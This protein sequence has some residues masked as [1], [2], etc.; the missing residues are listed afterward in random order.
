[1]ARLNYL[2]QRNVVDALEEA[3]TLA[4]RRNRMYCSFLDPFEMYSDAQFIKLYRLSKPLTMELIDLLEP[5]L[6]APSRKSALCIPRKILTTLR[7]LASGSYQLDVGRNMNHAVSQSSVSNV[8]HEVIDALNMPDIF[9]KYIHLPRNRDE[10]SDLRNKFYM[11]HNFPGI[12]GSI[13]CTHIAI[14]AP[15]R[16][17]YPEEAYVNRKGYHSLNV[18]LICDPDLEILNVCARY[19]GSSHD[20]YIFNNSAAYQYIRQLYNNGYT[21]F[22]FLGDSGYALRPW[23]LTPIQN[24]LPGSPEENYNI[25]Q[26][27]ARSIIER[28][29]GVLK[30]RF[31]CL[32][33]HRVLHYDPTT[34][35][36]IIN[37]CTVLHNMC[38]IHNIPPVEF[39]D[40]EEDNYIDIDYGIY[41]NDNDIIQVRNQGQELIAGRRLQQLLIRNH[42][43]NF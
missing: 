12:I 26:K 38:I 32:L 23:M 7:F 16:N 30:L 39:G 10:L 28:C 2:V 21:S 34:A 40:E 11:T 24:V 13:D 5:H 18:Q 4:D 31:R 37:A 6:T 33:K 22:S 29:N 3:E 15:K 27:Q 36:K 1:M 41:I 17:Q 9:N 14:V 19:P 35:S 43:R 42:F 20:S 25:R 8:I